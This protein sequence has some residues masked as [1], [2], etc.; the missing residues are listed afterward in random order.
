MLFN[1]DYTLTDENDYGPGPYQVPF[2]PFTPSSSLPISVIDDNVIEAD[3]EL[4]FFEIQ[5]PTNPGIGGRVT[6]SA[7]RARLFIVDDDS[8][9]LA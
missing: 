4:F 8:K 1:S 9:W 7:P 6:I 3:R 5:T 2:P